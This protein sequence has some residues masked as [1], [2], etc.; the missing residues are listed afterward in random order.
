MQKLWPNLTKPIPLNLTQPD[1][2]QANSGQP[3]PTQPCLILTLTRL[4]PT[5]RIPTLSNQTQP[6]PTR[7]NLV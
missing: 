5:Q 3:Y 6:C 7:P 2:T 1:Q 4:N